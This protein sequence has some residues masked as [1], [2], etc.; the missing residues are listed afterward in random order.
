M[1]EYKLIKEYPGSPRL[2]SVITAA[3]TDEDCNIFLSLDGHVVNFPSEYPEFFKKVE[4]LKQSQEPR[5]V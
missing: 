5:E 1:A 3:T 4:K 2:G